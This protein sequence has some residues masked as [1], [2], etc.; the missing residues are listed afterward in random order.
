[1]ERS[2]NGQFSFGS[3]T[4][5]SAEPSINKSKIKSQNENND[6]EKCALFSIKKDLSSPR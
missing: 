4:A 5:D 1:M 2:D 6:L 3:K